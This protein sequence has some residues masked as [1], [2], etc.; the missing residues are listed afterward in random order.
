MG[1][2]ISEWINDE[3]IKLW[4]DYEDKVEEENGKVP[5]L[6]PK[7]K[8]DKTLFVGL[9]PSCANR[10]KRVKKILDKDFEALTEEE[11]EDEIDDF[12]RWEY[13]LSDNK[14]NNI[15]KERKIPRGATEEGPYDYFRAFYRFCKKIEGY[16]RDWT[17]IQVSGQDD[18]KK[19]NWEHIDIFR[20][21]AK[22]EDIL[23]KKLD[24][25]LEKTEENDLASEQFD[26]FSKLLEKLEPMVI[27]V[28]SAVA[29][30]II[31]NSLEISCEYWSEEGFQ[32]IELDNKDI[33]VFFT[34]MLSVGYDKGSRKRLIW[35]V[36]K[37]KEWVER[38]R[39]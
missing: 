4:K 28:Q 37:A 31:K 24:I 35:H 26:K 20:T 23:K 15:I 6:Y 33:P 3:L 38:G 2:D 36:K 25:N 22:K 5:S 17:K 30:N 34:G 19:R 18:Y 16:K 21:I 13:P 39:G 27:I 7:L 9:N 8:K 32:T 12:F 10:K 11:I 1:N 29:R 14:I